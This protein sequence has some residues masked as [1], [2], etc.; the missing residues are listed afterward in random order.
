[1]SI[2]LIIGS[3]YYGKKEHDKFAEGASSANT[4]DSIVALIFMLIVS[5]FLSVGPWWLTKIIFLLISFGLLFIG[6]FLI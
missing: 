2:A 1:M 3:M 6:I 4:S 5:F